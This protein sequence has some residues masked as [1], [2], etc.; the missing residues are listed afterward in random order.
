MPCADVSAFPSKAKQ[1]VSKSHERG[2]QQQNDRCTPFC[3]CTCCAGFYL[4]RGLINFVLLDF[5]SKPTYAA[6]LSSSIIKVP[7][8]IW[9][10][11]KL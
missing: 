7:A 6:F 3:T 11:P 9:Q 1:Q 4:Q 10:P 8:T 5:L 2:G